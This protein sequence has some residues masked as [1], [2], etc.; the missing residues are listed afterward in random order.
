MRNIRKLIFSLL[1]AIPPLQ[2]GERDWMINRTVSAIGYKYNLSVDRPCINY[3]MNFYSSLPSRSSSTIV[4]FFL[5][6]SSDVMSSVYISRLTRRLA[7]LD[8][9]AND[10][11]R[12]IYL[13]I[14]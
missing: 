5:I 1:N 8:P 11:C 2:P 14:D 6:V 3:R 10:I 12:G 9:K 7:A 4:I 13:C